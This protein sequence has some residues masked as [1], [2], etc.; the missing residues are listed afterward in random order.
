MKNMRLVYFDQHG[1]SDSEQ[2]Q[3]CGIQQKPARDLRVGGKYLDASPLEP[4]SSST[5]VRLRSSKRLVTGI[6]VDGDFDS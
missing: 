5:S 6:G 2:Q 1:L 4:A 3:C